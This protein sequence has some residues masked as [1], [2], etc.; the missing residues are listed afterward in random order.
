MQ[1]ILE[2]SDWDGLMMS[3]ALEN[4]ELVTLQAEDEFGVMFNRYFIKLGDQLISAGVD[5]NFASLLQFALRRNAEAFA[6]KYE[7]EQN[8]EA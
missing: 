7:A 1:V 4:C 2:P 3:A 5:Q 8:S 6:E